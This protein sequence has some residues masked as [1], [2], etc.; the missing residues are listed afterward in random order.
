MFSQIFSSDFSQLKKK[1]NLLS[2]QFFFSVYVCQMKNIPLTNSEF[3]MGEITDYGRPNEA[4]FIE[5]QDFWNWA[6]KLGR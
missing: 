2:V 4:F 5:I 1:T 3:E 6:D